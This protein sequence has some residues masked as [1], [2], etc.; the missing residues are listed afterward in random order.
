VHPYPETPPSGATLNIH[1]KYPWL[2][3]MLAF[4]KPVATINGHQVP[5]Q[6]GDNPIPLQPGVY[7]VQIHVK[8]LWDV[9]RAQ[10]QVDNRTGAPATVYYAA[11]AILF[12]GGA[13]DFQPVKPPQEA[14]AIGL[15]IGLPV[16]LILLCCCFSVLGSLGGN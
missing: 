11:P 10:I 14:L 3:F 8:Y 13:I 5:L 9:G 2:A 16:L 6:W 12:V 4:F 7:D 15:G 1:T